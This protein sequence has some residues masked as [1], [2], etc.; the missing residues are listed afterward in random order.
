[1]L[2][3]LSGRYQAEAARADK[4]CTAVQQLTSADNSQRLVNGL[5][6]TSGPQRLT[7]SLKSRNL[8]LNRCPVRLYS[9]NHYPN[10]AIQGIHV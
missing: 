7:S 2:F 9:F 5:L 4:R 1:M 3:K 8:D 6:V 10:I